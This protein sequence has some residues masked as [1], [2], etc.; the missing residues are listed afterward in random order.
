[1]KLYRKD[2]AKSL[3]FMVRLHILIGWKKCINVLS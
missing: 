2:Q 3:H 1:M